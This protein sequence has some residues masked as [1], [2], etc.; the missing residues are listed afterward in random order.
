MN[1]TVPVG[2]P[3]AGATGA[4]VGTASVSI[5][6]GAPAAVNDPNNDDEEDEPATPDTSHS[7]G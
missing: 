5:I 7:R 3:E 6:I 4:T 1:V 2:V